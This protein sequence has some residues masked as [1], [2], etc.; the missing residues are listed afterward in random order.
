[1][2]LPAGRTAHLVSNSGGFREVRGRGGS[3]SPGVT[4]PDRRRD[5]GT[6]PRDSNLGVKHQQP[7]AENL[8]SSWVRMAICI[9][10]DATVLNNEPK[11]WTAGPS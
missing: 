10:G 11:E 7:N 8:R 1:M 2:L 3:A 9:F 4:H 5:G 6:S